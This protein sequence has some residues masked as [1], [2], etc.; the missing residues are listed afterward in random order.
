MIQKYIELSVFPV[1]STLSLSSSGMGGECKVVHPLYVQLILYLIWYIYSEG[2]NCSNVLW[3][4]SV[5]WITSEQLK[6]TTSKGVPEIYK[7]PG[8]IF[9]VK[10][11]ATPPLPSCLPNRVCFC[12]KM[13]CFF[14]FVLFFVSQDL[15]A[16]SRLLSTKTHYM[17]VV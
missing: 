1:D 17:C 14:F 3:C 13:V 9:F 7:L 2:Q 12:P 11:L 8:V 15:H 16:T 6:Q 5:S 4:W 10:A